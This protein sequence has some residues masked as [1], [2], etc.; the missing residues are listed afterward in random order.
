[1]GFWFHPVHVDLQFPPPCVEEPVF[2]STCVFAPLP[3]NAGGWSFVGSFRSCV[4]WLA[5]S[6]WLQ[7]RGVSVAVT[8]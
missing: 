5:C 4:C 6:C 2:S 1:M 8:L 3:L 7:R